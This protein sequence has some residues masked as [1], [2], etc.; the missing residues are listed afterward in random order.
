[1]A[2]R[3]PI[4]RNS[5]VHGTTLHGRKIAGV[6]TDIIKY[7]NGTYIEVESKTGERVR[8]RASLLR[9]TSVRA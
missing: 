5:R 6:V 2:V 4:E 1:M 9:A 7:T 8:T 3:K